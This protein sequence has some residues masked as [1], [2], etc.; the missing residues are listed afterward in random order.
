LARRR[1]HAKGSPKASTIAIYASIFALI[2]ALV[3][4]G[5]RAPQQAEG[6]ANA[7]APTSDPLMNQTSV[8]QLVATNLAASLAETTNLTVAKNVANLSVSLTAKSEL[9][10]SNDAII[11]KPQIIQP[12]TGSRAII[13]YT[14]N[15][16]DTV[17]SIASQYN[18]STNTVSWANNLTSD[19][20][21]T[22]KTLKILPL[23]GVLYTV[24]AGDT[25]ESIAS[26]YSVNQ[27]RVS[28]YNDLEVS[29]LVV[30]NQI[31]L[32]GATLPETERPGYVAPR[33]YYP[34]DNGT[35]YAVGRS[36][37]YAASAGNRYTY[38]Y[39]TWYAYNRRAE[40]GRSIGSFWG[41]ASNWSRAARSAGLVVNNTPEAGAILEGGGSTWQGHVAVVESIAA[42]GDVTVSEMNNATYGGWGIT[43]MRTISAGQASLYNYIH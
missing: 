23:D 38:G 16:S 32:P 5:Y 41:D 29:G 15:G 1:K 11:S 43:D 9:A 20:V 30:G 31:I 3:S 10:Q 6:I 42:N 18:I 27:S 4:I 8:D 2:V 12:A 28:L 19:S 33:T 22:G 21:A 17:T 26:R 14:T 34:V 36:S 25:F 35:G 40:L 37:I 13:S 39:C 24:K 7:A